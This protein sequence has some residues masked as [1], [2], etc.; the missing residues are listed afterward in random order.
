MSAAEHIVAPQGSPLAA[1]L[2]S[3]EDLEASVAFWCGKVGF[4]PVGEPQAASARWN[5]LW[6][7]P[8]T[9]DARSV[10]LR[11]CGLAVGQ[12]LLVEWRAAGRQRIRVA[13]DTRAYGLQNV[14]CYV[15]N[16]DAGLA[17]LVAAG[18]RAWSAPTRHEFGPAVGAP[19]EVVA[20]VIDGVALNLVELATRDPATR[21]GQMRAYVAGI[22]Y[23]GRGFT[24]VVTTSHVVRSIDD[25]VAF[26]RDVLGMG[27]LIDDEL[28]S[29]A[30]NLFL[31]LSPGC[32]TRVTFTQGA[33]MFGKVAMSG[34]MNYACDDLAPRAHAPNIGYLAQVFEVRDLVA[35]RAA[36]ARLGTREEA[37]LHDVDVAG[38]GER[39]ALLLRHPASGAPVL[40][41]QREG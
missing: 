33:H 3:V 10:L 5:A 20:E 4:E 12:I 9:T 31:R 32:R 14:N 18:G 29:D 13:E 41:L 23:T 37:F 40:I 27:V 8:S 35:A 30:A 11:A 6:G 34:P 26:Y 38:F 19:I 7:L 39:D 28:K 1:A 21:I 16:A 2:I 15:E 22:G 36:A 17:E 25:G 24:P